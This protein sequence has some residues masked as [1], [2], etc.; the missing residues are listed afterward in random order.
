M[1][2]TKCDSEKVEYRE[3]DRTE[4]SYVWEIECKECGYEET[5]F[6]F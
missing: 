2:C 6:E 1:T 3:Y 5:G 4:S